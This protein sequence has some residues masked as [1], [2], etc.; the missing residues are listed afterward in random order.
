LNV[1]CWTK[2]AIAVVLAIGVLSTVAFFAQ[3]GFGDGHGRLDI[4]VAL[5]GLPWIWL[6]DRIALPPIIEQHDL[7]LIVWFPTLL[8]VIVVWAGVRV[9]SLAAAK[10][11]S[12]ARLKSCPDTNRCR[13]AT[14]VAAVW[15]APLN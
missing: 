4:L 12:S 15:N 1:R 7:L 3:G 13:R 6:L 11:S 2:A 8:N 9:I 10:I 14:E 5:P